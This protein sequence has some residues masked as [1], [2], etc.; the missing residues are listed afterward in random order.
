MF[1]KDMLH[2]QHYGFFMKKFLELLGGVPLFEGIETEDLARMLECLGAIVRAFKRDDYVWFAGDGISNVGVVLNGRVCVLKEDIHG[3]RRI[4]A[5]VGPGNVFGETLAFSQAKESPVTVQ[6]C[7]DAAVLFVDF[8]RIC[9]I[10]P[11][12]CVFH[13]RLIRNM[14]RLIAEKNRVLNEKLDI[15][16]M[17]TTREKIG[18]YLTNQAQAQGKTTVT[19]PYDRGALADYLCV[20]RSALSRELG[21]MREEG[22]IDFHRNV[23]TL[24]KADLTPKTG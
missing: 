22:L 20:N 23:F 18:A 2:L 5:T 19:V 14:L 17:R 21:K 12:A 10:C 8:R 6:A 3:N 16:G 7:S 15:L 4:L 11:N 24:K 13:S 9:T 1:E